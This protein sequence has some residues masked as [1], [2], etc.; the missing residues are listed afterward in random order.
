MLILT[1]F[2][3]YKKNFAL[4]R[5]YYVL[6]IHIAVL[7]NLLLLTLSL[8]LAAVLLLSRPRI[9]KPNLRDPLAEAGHLGYPLKVLSVGVA[10]HLKVS[11]QDCKLLLGK[12]CPHAFRLATFATVL[13]IAILR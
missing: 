2:N 5:Y 4:F 6:Y 8:D 9:L 13:G 7:F 10:V 11:L 12:G 3:A 1:A